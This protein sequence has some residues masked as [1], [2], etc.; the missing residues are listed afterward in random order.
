[1]TGS[2]ALRR[3]NSRLIGRRSMAGALGHVD[4]GSREPVA[5]ISLVDIGA[6]DRHPG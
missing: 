2:M 1:M 5:A 6:G 3:R 4:V